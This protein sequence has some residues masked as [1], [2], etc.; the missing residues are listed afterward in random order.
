MRQRAVDGGPRMKGGHAG[1]IELRAQELTRVLNSVMNATHSV[2]N[3]YK[4]TYARVQ[5]L[6]EQAQSEKGAAIKD[7]E[8]DEDTEPRTM[9][10]VE[11]K[12]HQYTK[13]ESVIMISK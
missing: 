4:L 7:K 5:S 10:N 8:G 11:H 2:N 1:A 3:Y 13:Y 12:S 9:D 6:F